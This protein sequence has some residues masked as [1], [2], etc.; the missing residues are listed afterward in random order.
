MV[1]FK[2]FDGSQLLTQEKAVLEQM[3]NI[4]SD[5]DFLDDENVLQYLDEPAK[6]CCMYSGSNLLGFAWLALC[7]EQHI[8]ELCW[9]VS[10][11]KKAKGLDS[12]SLLDTTLEYCKAKGIKSLKFNCAEQSWGRIKNKEQLFKKFGY[13]L[14]PDETDYDMSIDI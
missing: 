13:T 7:E 14:T 12:K 6:V 8:A 4:S 3:Q 9:F 11:K 5:Y 2:F 1:E 10:D